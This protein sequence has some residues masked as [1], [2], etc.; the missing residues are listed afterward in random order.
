MALSRPRHESA[1]AQLDEAVASLDTTRQLFTE[2]V[3]PVDVDWLART[4]SRVRKA[5][6][7]EAM[8]GDLARRLGELQRSLVSVTTGLRLTCDPAGVDTITMPPID[9]IREH[10][11]RHAQATSDV[12]RVTDQIADLCEQRVRVKDQM[13]LALRLAAL[14]H[15]LDQRGPLPVILDDL[16]V[17]FDDERTE[18]GLRVL[19]ELSSRTQVLLVSHHRAVAQSATH[20]EVSSPVTV[21]YLGE[22]AE[23]RSLH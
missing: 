15:V 5:G 11:D 17:H 1:T 18:A 12:R 10:R 19:T 14:E 16:F 23:T 20:V 22:T 9:E 7:L 21:H 3:E 6:D 2:L 13:Y 8:R 4:V